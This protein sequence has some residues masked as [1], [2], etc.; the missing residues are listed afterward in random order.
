MYNTHCPEKHICTTCHRKTKSLPKKTVQLELREARKEIVMVD[1][2]ISAHQ[3]SKYSISAGAEE[4]EKVDAAMQTDPIDV[5]DQNEQYFDPYARDMQI[6]T[7]K[8]ADVTQ[9][10]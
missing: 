10:T 1:E 4:W 3:F 8:F 6:Q 7:E 2:D 9:I 5:N